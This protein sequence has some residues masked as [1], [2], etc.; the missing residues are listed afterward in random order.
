MLRR[1]WTYFLLL[2]LTADLQANNVRIEGDVR[3]KDT[4]VDLETNVATVRLT[5]KWDNSW[6]DDFNHDAVYL[7][8]KYKVDGEGEGWHHAYLEPSGHGLRGK[9]GVRYGYTM[10]NSRAG[11]SGGERHNEGIFIYRTTP[12]YGDAEVDVELKWYIKSNPER[13]VDRVMFNAG[14]VLLS[15][16]GI[17][18]VYI[19]RGGFRAG[20][21][22][23]AYTFRNGNTVFPP[24]S[25]ILTDA[26]VSECL[27]AHPLSDYPP[28]FAINRMDDVAADSS[29]AWVGSAGGPTDAADFAD[30][31]QVNLKSGVAVRSFAIEC[32]DGHAPEE[33]SLQAVLGGSWKS[34]YPV[35][36]DESVYAGPGDWA[37][38]SRQTYP[39]TKTLRVDQAFV[40]TGQQSSSYRI[41]VHRSSE[42]PVIKN[43]AM[44]GEDV[45]SEVDNS[46]FVYDSVTALDSLYGLYSA[47]GDRWRG[48]TDADYPNGYK[49]FYA[50]KYEVSQEQYVTFLNKLT[51]AQ[52]RARTV[53][54]T[55]L[56]AM[57]EG[58]YLF[59][60]RRNAANAWNGIKLAKKGK[61]DVPYVF[62]ND[63]DPSNAGYSQDGDGQTVACNYLNAGDMLAYAD[64][65]GLRPMTELE[66]EKMARRPYPAGS[67]RG[68]YVW[69]TAE[70]FTAASGVSNRGH[71]NE[72]PSNGN[73][74]AKGRLSGP[75]RCGAFAKSGSQ[76]QSGASFWGVMDLGG[77]LSEIYYNANSNGRLYRGYAD[78]DH[79]DGHIDGEGRSDIGSTRWPEMEFAFGTRGGSF[80]DEEA[81]TRI[82]DRLRSDSVFMSHTEANGKK[83][84]TLT[85]R[86]GRTAP[87]YHGYADVT[88]ENGK[89]SSEAGATDSVC[90]GSDYTIG[91]TVPEEIGG[92]YHI[93]W[94]VS[95]DGGA[96]WD[97]VRGV[98]TPYLRLEG[99]RNENSREDVFKDYWYKRYIYTD[100][101]D[102]VQHNPVRVRVI[103]TRLTL[104]RD[105]DT[106]DVNDR[107]LGVR[108][109]S[110][111]E[112]VYRWTWLRDNVNTPVSVEYVL[113]AGKVERHHFEYTDFYD[114]SQ[115]EG[116]QKV[117]LDMTVMRRCHFRDTIRVYVEAKPEERNNYDNRTQAH[118]EGF[119][120]GEILIDNEE[121]VA[122]KRRYRTVKIGEKCWMA[123]NLCRTIYGNKKGTAFCYDN[124]NGEDNAY[125]AR[126]GRLY[127]WL[128]ATQDDTTG[129]TQGIC[130][131]G[132][133]LPTNDEWLTLLAAAGT[134]VNTEGNG[135]KMRSPLNDWRPTPE[136][137]MIGTNELGFNAM[138]GGGY[139][140]IYSN[141]YGYDGTYGGFDA[142]SGFCDLGDQGWWWTSTNRYQVWITAHGGSGDYGTCM[143]PYYVR[144]DKNAGEIINNVPIEWSGHNY[145][146]MNS[147][148]SGNEHHYFLTPC[149]VD[150]NRDAG[151]NGQAR[152]N[153]RS[154]FYFS[155]R[156]VLD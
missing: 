92:A 139:F 64:W 62:A 20:D 53:G 151:C 127:N 142:R 68:E 123:E 48:V 125:C 3:V 130:P 145:G 30:Y 27:S 59:G 85:F 24:E 74:N 11:V 1:F 117:E 58:D 7:F 61:D 95:S 50:M 132:W 141:Y 66:Y 128:A 148:F 12:G 97:W 26:N 21:T 146:Y 96:N 34:V 116:D 29:N 129:G 99:M 71:K 101:A 54:A 104:S 41:L 156:C 115:F 131:A 2:A 153:M 82:S 56:S 87:V 140:Y 31:W 35:Y 5:L 42:T 84:S 4:D 52:Q 122:V 38:G 23:S 88:L 25:D 9:G 134:E 149:G 39:C 57:E 33:W 137:R 109:E 110:S 112:A 28:S 133:H 37:G 79:G 119:V 103:N 16:M 13:N 135:L 32:L 47:D 102:Y 63:L 147:I 75:V 121:P 8:L 51:A 43:V 15:A 93:A 91:G 98:E 86:L 17:E 45:L 144:F 81:R 124:T 113:K 108:I 40:A 73:I 118:I 150:W 100:S 60:S 78:A 136:E 22:Q 10:S 114:G 46:V 76:V 18:M 55:A 89:V 80:Q 126:Y 105:S 83:D 36:G 72:I 67:L 155:V 19:P 44:S 152:D 106:V 49:A 65:C 138:P 143:M 111:Q 14:N 69:N 90:H 120:C 154:Q 77:N 70:D 94:M 107:S 6:H